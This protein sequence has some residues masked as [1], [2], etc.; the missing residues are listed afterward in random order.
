MIILLNDEADA[1]WCFERL[2]RRLVN[3]LSLDSILLLTFFNTPLFY[4]L[5]TKLEGGFYLV[6]GYWIFLVF[7]GNFIYIGFVHF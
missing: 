4:H 6:F 7:F 2:M 3:I 1:F 5:L